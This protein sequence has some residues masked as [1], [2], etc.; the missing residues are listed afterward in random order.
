MFFRKKPEKRNYLEISFSESVQAA[1]E[2]VYAAKHD[3]LLGNIERDPYI[4]N[5]P[6]MYY[7]LIGIVDK[8]YSLVEKEAYFE[9]EISMLYVVGYVILFLR[10]RKQKDSKWKVM[11]MEYKKSVLVIEPHARDG[12]IAYSGDGNFDTG[13]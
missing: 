9:R 10:K 7:P 11:S 5:A 13:Y 8:Q 2:F 4:T 1:V 6:F 3:K 12:E